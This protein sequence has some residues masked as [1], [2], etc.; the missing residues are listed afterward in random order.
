MERNGKKE[1]SYHKYLQRHSIDIQ[2]NLKELDFLDIV[3][4]LQNSTYCPYRKSNDQHQLVV[5]LFSEN[6]EK[7]PSSIFE[8]LSK[9]CSSQVI[10]DIAKVECEDT[11]KE[12]SYDVE[13]HQSNIK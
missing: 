11:L 1:K 5:E 9:Y 2:I 12:L 8:K 6:H 7:L 13:V 4:N 10:S 3:L